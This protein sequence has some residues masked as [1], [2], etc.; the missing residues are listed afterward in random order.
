MLLADMSEAMTK[1]PLMKA[2]IKGVED[3]MK[4][5][6]LENGESIEGWKVVHGRQARKWKD[7]DTAVKYLKRRVPKFQHNFCTLKFMSPAQVE[8]KLKLVEPRKPVDLD[9]LIETVPG[10]PTIAPD[11][12]K[13]EAMVLGDK[14]ADDFAG[15]DDDK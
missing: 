12:D 6:L 15:L 9:G 1:V 8:K 11:S 3:A 13:R 10:K 14:A 7:E 5:T 4:Q 2:W